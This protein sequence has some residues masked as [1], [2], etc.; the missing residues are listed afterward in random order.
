MRRL[1]GK[2]AMKQLKNNIGFQNFPFYHTQQ[3]Y[4]LLKQI[5]SKKTEISTPQCITHFKL[6]SFIFLQSFTVCLIKHLVGY[7][8]ITILFYNIREEKQIKTSFATSIFPIE[9][10]GEKQK[11]TNKT[12]K[13]TFHLG[14]I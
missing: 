7:A 9:S 3:F 4:L 8:C 2:L 6:L 10:A 11:I 14:K 13:N 1:G 5:A 12:R